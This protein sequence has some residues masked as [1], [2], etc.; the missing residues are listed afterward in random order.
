MTRTEQIDRILRQVIEGENLDVMLQALSPA[1]QNLFY[2]LVAEL[3]AGGDLELEDLWKVDYTRRPPTMEEFV[4][5]PYWLGDIAKHTEDNEGIFPEWKRIVCQDF[6]LDSRLHNVVITG[7]LGCG[8]CS[9]RGTYV[10]MYDGSTKAVENIVPGDKLMGDNSQVRTVLNTFTGHGKIYEI[11]PAKGE[12]FKVSE[13]HILCLKSTTSDE[14]REVSVADFLKWPRQHKHTA[15]IY[16]TGVDWPEQEVPLDPYWLGLWLGDGTTVRPELTS[17]DEVLATYFTEYG[18]GLGCTSGVYTVGRGAKAKLY[19]LQSGRAVQHKTTNPVIQRLN[20]LGLCFPKYSDKFT[21]KFIPRSYLTN[22]RKVRLELLAGLIDTDGSLK[23]MGTGCYEITLKIKQLAEDVTFLARSLGYYVS[24]TIKIVNATAYY[25]MGISGAYDIPVKLDRKRSAPRIAGSMG[26]YDK[27][28]VPDSTKS[29]FAVIPLEDDTYYGFE[30]DGNHRYLFRDFTVTHNSWNSALIILY[31]IVLSRLLRNPFG[32]L[33]LSK[34]SPVVFALLSVTRTA[35]QETIFGDVLNFMAH[36]AFFTEECKFNIEKK[37]ASLRIP[38]GNN[39]MLV[40]GSQG[41]HVLGRNTLAVAMDEGNWRRE[42]NPD[43]KAYKLY[44]EIRHRITNRFQKVAGFMPGICLLASSARDESS[45]TEQVITDINNVNDERTQRVYRLAAFRVKRAQLTLKPTWFRV[46]FGLKTS[47]P[48]ILKGWYREDG[49]LIP[50]VEPDEVPP[51][52]RTTLVPEDYLPDFKRNVTTSLQSICGESTGGAFKL[53][54]DFST[55]EMAVSFGEQ[56]GLVNPCTVTQVPL[57]NDDSKEMWDFL[58]HKTFVQRQL[59]RFLPKRDPGQPRFAHYDLATVNQ[60][61]L[62]I[63]HVA[64]RKLVDGLYDASSGKVFSQYRPIIE[65]DFILAIVPGEQKEISLIKIQNFLF[66]LRDRCGYP[67]GIVTADS[68]QSSMPLELLEVQGFKTEL[69]SIDKTKDPYYSWRAGFS[70]HLVRMFR[71][72][73]LMAETESLQ[74]L[75]KKIDHPNPGCFSGDTRIALLDGRN[76]TLRELAAHPEEVWVYAWNGQK[77]V[78]ARAEKP[79]CTSVCAPTVIVTLDSGE[80]ITCTPDHRFML[81]DGSYGEAKDLLPGTSLMP[82][83]RK[84][85]DASATYDKMVGY[86]MYY[87]PGDFKWHYTHRM[88][89]RMINPSYSK[90][91]YR[92][93]V[94]EALS[95]KE[96]VKEIAGRVGCSLGLVY[97]YKRT[98]NHKVM[99]VKPGPITDVYDISVPGVENFA[100][101]SGVFVHNSKDVADSACG[102]YF[103]AV[104]LGLGSIGTDGAVPDLWSERSGTD[105]PPPIEFKPPVSPPAVHSF[106]G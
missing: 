11:Y 94:I 49:T 86:E 1:D 65:Y 104:R 9:P 8:K 52:A 90:T 99:S 76:A 81:R 57:S 14:V 91:K 31:R 92:S 46:A 43:E 68:F 4:E 63:C 19:T 22:S 61:G 95:S 100:L 26:Q 40:A 103:N 25:R 56:A 69:L 44:D 38:L 36:S 85:T 84:V 39:M 47:A 74:D 16:H 37:Y 59:G 71:H 20:K 10:I 15:C 30:L 58:D 5:D 32:F 60:A 12:P 29:R 53:F 102:A 66:W 6:N 42:A 83:R 72:P 50:G 48:R 67:F 27:R 24:T 3:R 21:E 41:Q 35:V 51:G 62:S 89:G 55:V 82:L 64:G 98:L 97:F 75:P 54:S 45:F 70:E 96:S 80:E 34:G 77:I 101:T 93:Q 73:L 2:D 23:S 7:S 78:P 28:I 17:A 105:T 33:G 106:E 79:R 87:C 88:V 18:I 13:N